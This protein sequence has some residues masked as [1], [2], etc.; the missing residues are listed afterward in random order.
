[1]TGVGAKLPTG[2]LIYRKKLSVFLVSDTEESAKASRNKHLACRILFL[3]WILS[4]K[5]AIFGF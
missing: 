5:C 3:I 2:E 1:M 4:P